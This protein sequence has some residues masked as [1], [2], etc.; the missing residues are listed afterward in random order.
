MRCCFLPLLLLSLGVAAQ[1]E[2]DK[3]SPRELT[4]PTSPLFD[5]MGQAPSQV[6]RTADIRDFKV[7][8][9][10]RNWKLSPNLAIEAQPVWEIAYNRKGISK[11]Q[12]AKPLARRLSTLDVSLGTVQ[13]EQNDRRIGWAL[14]MNL[15]RQHDPLLLKGVYD[16]INEAFD[17]EL[18]QLRAKEKDLLARL[19]TALHP[20]RLKALRDE[21]RQNDQ[22]LGSFY[23]RRNTAIQERAKGYVIEHWNSAFIDFAFGKI[24]T[25]GTDSTGSLGKLRVNRNTGSGAW[26]NFGVGIGKRGLLSGLVRS[27][28]YEEELTF[29]LRD[30]ATGNEEAVSAIAANRL[31]TFGV[32][33]RYGGPIYSF[34]VEFLRE[35]KSLKTPVQALNEA[36]TAPGGKVVVTSTVKWDVVQPYSLNIGGDWRISRNVILNYGLRCVFDNNLKATTFIPI[37]NI[38]CMMR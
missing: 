20:A 19:D 32:N 13:N 14:K 2:K 18:M 16:D 31:Y 28:F 30:E 17:A 4:I 24:Y 10:F 12:R 33:M 8:W 11:Y 23:Y 9:S 1:E 38:S 29:Q 25:Y 3:L 6:A 5:L 36:F 35:A 34:F 15:Y 26:L 7:D 27:S 21:L 37:A 22:Q